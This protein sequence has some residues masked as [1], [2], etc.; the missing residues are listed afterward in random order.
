[1][2]AIGRMLPTIEEFIGYLQHERKRSANTLA[3][4]RTDLTQFE[5]FVRSHGETGWDMPSATVQA[6]VHDL[7]SRA[8]EASSQARKLAAVKSF[9]RWLV[10][11]GAVLSDPAAD[12]GGAPVRKRRPTVL[13]TTQVERLLEQ[14]AIDQAPER[15]RDLAMLETL[16][17][18]G[19]RASELVALD[20]DDFRA[21]GKVLRV[22][23]RGPRERAITLS[24]RAGR[25]LL[26]YLEL[27]RPN[28]LRRRDEFSMFL[29]HR[30]NRLTRQGFWLIVKGYAR[31]ADI[32]VPITPHTLRHSF[33]THRMRAEGD[34][35]EVQRLLGHASIA[36]TR[37]YADLARK[38]R[39]DDDPAAHA[40]A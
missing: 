3:A 18:S 12:I 4:Y 23:R 34:V 25:A 11:R 38:Q 40:R 29:N 37:I 28:L 26:A 21:S 13:S 14:A 8:Y 39:V 22:G 19:I 24:D 9:Y 7:V 35:R 6:F 20:V 10:G 16:Y 36:T 31:L 5:E 32:R 27:A 30:G 17:A 33:A 1:M 2:A 15:R